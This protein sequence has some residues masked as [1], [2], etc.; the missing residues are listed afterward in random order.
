MKPINI[1]NC[2]FTCMSLGDHVG[3]PVSPVALV[4]IQ[5]SSSVSKRQV[6]RDTNSK[7]VNGA[8]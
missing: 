3:E 2:I 4:S 7:F 8:L 6:N 5:L 1:T